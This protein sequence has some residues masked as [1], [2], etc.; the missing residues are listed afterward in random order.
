MVFLSARFFFLGC[1]GSGVRTTDDDLS[2]VCL[3][4]LQLHSLKYGSVISAG[5]RCDAL[6]VSLKT[7]EGMSPFFCIQWVANSRQSVAFPHGT[8]SMKA[9]DLFRWFFSCFVEKSPLPKFSSSD[10]SLILSTLFYRLQHPWCIFLHLMSAS[11]KGLSLS[12]CDLVIFF[13]RRMSAVW[14]RWW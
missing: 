7:R 12:L 9:D 11:P 3:I 1:L 13:Q 5:F 14:W 2:R 4:T 8:S 6:R 10:L